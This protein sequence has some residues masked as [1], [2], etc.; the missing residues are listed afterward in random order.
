MK[1]IFTSALLLSTTLASV[2]PRAGQKVNYD[3]FKIL[4]VAP[5][6]ENKSQVED[7][8]AHILNPG[9]SDEIDVV[10]APENLDALTALVADSQVLSEDVG[11]DLKKEGEMGVY[12]G[13][14]IL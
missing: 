3:G 14:Y 13:R 11:A 6:E 7:L 4:R 9:H 1:T 5:T 2:V 10:V 12:A 8:A